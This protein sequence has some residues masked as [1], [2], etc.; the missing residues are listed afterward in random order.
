VSVLTLIARN[1][2]LILHLNR[3]LIL[4]SKYSRGGSGLM[5]A[6]CGIKRH[7]GCNDGLNSTYYFQ[8]QESSWQNLA[9][10]RCHLLFRQPCG[11]VNVWT[12]GEHLICTILT[13]S[14]PPRTM[15]LCCPKWDHQIKSNSFIPLFIS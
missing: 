9:S 8:R 10:H 4:A 15:S 13:K 6:S 12:R 1:L 2:Y 14:Q 11:V 5:K 3:A 7:Y